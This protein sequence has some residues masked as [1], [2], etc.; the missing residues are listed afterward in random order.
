MILS[1]SIATFWLTVCRKTG[2]PST[3]G[4]DADVPVIE[5]ELRLRDEVREIRQTEI[6]INAQDTDNTKAG[7]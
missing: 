7:S 4:Q 5:R 2:P 3:I 1:R 6:E